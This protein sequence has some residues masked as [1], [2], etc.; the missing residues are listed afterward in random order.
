[1]IK[2]KLIHAH[3]REITASD[4][5]SCLAGKTSFLLSPSIDGLF[6][7]L[8]SEGN[9]D[10]R[11]EPFEQRREKLGSLLASAVPPVHLTPATRELNVA[12]DWF[13]SFEGAGLDGVMARPI[14]GTYQPGEAQKVASKLA[15]EILPA[16]C[17]SITRKWF[18]PRPCIF[19][20]A[21]GSRYSVI[22]ARYRQ[23]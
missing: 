4:S 13:R 3:V 21:A 20:D 12:S 8:P 17:P 1:L 18:S 15:S 9:R 16:N 6:F 14:S 22:R 10:W 19:N 11:T 5:S 2:Q 7:D 23:R